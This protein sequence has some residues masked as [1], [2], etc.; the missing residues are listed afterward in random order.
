MQFHQK[1]KYCPVCGS[2]HFTVNNFKSKRCEDCGF[3]YYFNPS[4][5][6]AAFILNEKNELMVCRRG[7][8]PAKGTLDLPGGFVDYNE[9]VEQAITREIKEETN[10]DIEGA[11]YLFSLP[12]DYMYSDL[13]IPTLDMFYECKL[14]DYNNL[15][16]ADDVEELFFIPIDK[17]N[18][19][20][21][22]LKS[23]KKAV[24]F[25]IDGNKLQN[26]NDKLW[27]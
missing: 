16:A 25:F 19:L 27:V 10:G 5:S 26:K 17:I 24:R 3:V 8:E 1:F 4:S 22:G 12:N 2:S 20:L 21:F 18:P 7:N 11:K 15:V 13:N 14:K 23:V 6:C 9:S